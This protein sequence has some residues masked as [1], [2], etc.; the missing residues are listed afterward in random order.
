MRKRALYMNGN[1]EDNLQRIAAVQAECPE[2]ILF[3]QPH[4]SR[5]IAYLRD[6]PPT[7]E[8][9]VTVYI[10]ISTDMNK[11][12]FTAEVVGW[13]D[14]TKLSPQRR[15]VID[16]VIKTKQ[17]PEPG[18]YDVGVNLIHIRR[19]VRVASPF[20]VAK[21]VKTSSDEPL[22][23]KSRSGGFSYVKPLRDDAGDDAE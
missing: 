2:Q 7:E 12:H 23:H 6:N 15:A 17:A 22:K 5:Y 20:D 19:L 1:Y 3:I 21:L 8:D 11:V 10:S 16:E 4:G 18:V 13:D 9:P 14:K